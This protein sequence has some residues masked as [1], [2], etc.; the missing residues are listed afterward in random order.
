MPKLYLMLENA[1]VNACLG[2]KIHKNH[3][4]MRES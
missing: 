4:K 3:S 2:K 1:C